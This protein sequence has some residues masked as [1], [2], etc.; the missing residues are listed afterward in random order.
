MINDD[1]T[2]NVADDDDMIKEYRKPSL[3]MALGKKML[4]SETCRDAT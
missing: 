3:R 2:S 4:M 1:S